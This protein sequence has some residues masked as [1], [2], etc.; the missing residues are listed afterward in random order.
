MKDGAQNQWPSTAADL[1]FRETIP[2]LKPYDRS[3]SKNTERDV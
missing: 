2:T 3:T 1:K